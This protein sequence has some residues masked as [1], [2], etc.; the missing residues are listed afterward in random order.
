[1]DG[2]ISSGVAD[3]QPPVL[4]SGTSRQRL[5]LVSKFQHWASL[6]VRTG[7]SA[8]DAVDAKAMMRAM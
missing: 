7:A 6:R 3:L 5:V 4:V 1:M 8:A 2:L